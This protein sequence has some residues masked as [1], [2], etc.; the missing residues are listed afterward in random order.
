MLNVYLVFNVYF[1]MGYSS[2]KRINKKYFV[3]KI[4]FDKF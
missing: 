3:E 2:G 4:L 1:G